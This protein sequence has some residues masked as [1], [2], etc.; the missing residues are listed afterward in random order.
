MRYHSCQTIHYIKPSSYNSQ[1][2]GL[3]GP[4]TATHPT[5]ATLLGTNTSLSPLASTDDDPYTASLLF[6]APELLGARWYGAS[7][8]IGST[9]RRMTSRSVIDAFMCH[10]PAEKLAWCRSF[11]E[12]R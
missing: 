12:A 11:L 6:D 7:A 4:T 1:K 2:V 3:F 8:M 5:F 9:H 10:P